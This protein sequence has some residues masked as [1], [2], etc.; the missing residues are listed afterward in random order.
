VHALITG[1]QGL[2]G[3]YFTRYL[4]EAGW[5]LTF[6]DLKQ[7]EDLHLFVRE[8]RHA[9]YDLIV[10]CA[11]IVGGRETIE[12]S[13]LRVAT[14]LAIDAEFFDWAV[15]THQSRLVYFS[16]SAA[17]PIAC[18]QKDGPRLKEN[19]IDLDRP[20]MPDF[21]YGWAKLTGEHLARYA[22]EQYGLKVFVLRPF[23]GYAPDQDLS[24]PFPAF[25]QR[26]RRGE[27]PF[28][29]WGDGTAKRDFIHMRDV[30][31]GT[32]AVVDAGYQEPVNLC[33]GIGT[34][35]NELAELFGAQNVVH[36]L[37]KPVGVQDRVGD[38]GRMNQFYTA[39][40]TLEQGIKE[41]L[42]YER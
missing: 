30:V 1:D 24:Y 39:T 29:V 38:P 3:R 41:A 8:T 42:D 31:A 13:P 36:D 20:R 14:D 40:T 35:F 21:T 17:Y 32:M 2:V 26:A 5:E 12:G 27:D 7:G 25:A 37:A 33:T 6:V 34:S 22:R 10:H 11:A 9:H 18:Q 16:S 4:D 23:S 19:M 28:M 15:R